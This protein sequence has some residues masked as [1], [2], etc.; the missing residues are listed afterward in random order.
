MELICVRQIEGFTVGKIYTLQGCAGEYVQLID[1]DGQMSI[2]YES[3][4]DIVH[5]DCICGKGE[6]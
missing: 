1:D 2:L 3:Y 6:K 4:F 5:T